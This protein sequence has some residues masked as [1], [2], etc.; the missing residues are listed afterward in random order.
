MHGTFRKMSF[1]NPRRSEAHF[2]RQVRTGSYRPGAG[3]IAA[4]IG[5]VE[6]IH[7]EIKEGLV[8]NPAM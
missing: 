6:R 8:S 7:R 5:G 3:V 4:P 2:G 1:G